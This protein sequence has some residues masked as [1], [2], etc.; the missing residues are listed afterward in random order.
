MA[1]Q[2]DVSIEVG[3]ITD[4]E[5]D[6]IKRM[7]GRREQAPTVAESSFGGP[8]WK[9]VLNELGDPFD[10]SRI[11]MKKRY[12]MRLDPMIAF[13][14]HY[15]EVPLATVPWHINARDKNGARA[16]VA[17]FFD[18]AWRPIHAS[19]VFQH[20]MRKWL[21]YVPIVERFEA[22]N[23]GG[24]Y[25]DPRESD[26]EKQEK[27][28]WDEGPNILPY[29]W[30]HFVALPPERCDPRWDD[31]NGAF[32][33]ITY[34]PPGTLERHP[35]FKSRKNIIKK[36]AVREIDIF[37]SLWITN[38]RHVNFNSIYGYPAVGRAYPY[39][40]SYWFRWAMSDRAFERHAVPP[41]LAYHPEGGTWD[42]D[43]GRNIPNWQIALEAAD[44]LR[45]NAIAAVPSSLET[46]GID[47]G[48]AM[49]AWRFEFLQPSGENFTWMDESFNYL[50]VMKLRSMWVPEQAFIEGEGGTSSR[51]VAAA[52]AESFNASQELDWNDIAE[53][54]NRWIFPNLAQTNYQEFVNN[55]GVVEIVGHGFQQ[56]D[57][58]FAAQIIQLI[59]QEDPGQFGIDG[60]ELLRRLKIPL[61]SPRE[62]ERDRQKVVGA[63]TLPP[64][65]EPGAASVG[66]IPRPKATPLNPGQR[67]GGSL[68]EPRTG[69]AADY[70]MVYIQ[71]NEVI[72]L[73]D[74]ADF[75]A[76]LP[77]SKHY[78]DKQIK[79]LAAQLRRMWAGHY[80][81]LYPNFAKYVGKQ[82]RFD[83]ADE[84]VS[85][86]GVTKK[87]AIKAANALLGNWE[88]DS[89]QMDSLATRSRNIIEK[90]VRR[91]IKLEQD[92][93]GDESDITEDTIEPFVNEQVGRLMKATHETVRD[94][95]KTFL[96]NEIREGKTPTE[97]G[98]NISNH[99]NEF[100][101]WQA[102]RV[103]RAETRDSV[104]AGTLF[105]GEAAKVKYTRMHDGEEHDEECRKRN[106]KL[107]TIKEAWKELRKEH[108]YGTLGFELLPRATFSVEH[109]KTLDDNSPA[110]FDPEKNTAFVTM[111]L[112]DDDLQTFFNEVIDY[113]SNGNGV[114][115]AS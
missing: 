98:Q 61:K 82:E 53:S 47:G 80:R 70:D 78:E 49:P 32:N 28:I 108:P 86:R 25:I 6:K 109:V 65:V 16:D 30:K 1:D 60:Q 58:D 81:M 15:K 84:P 23:P 112:S 31:R 56:A 97:I 72:I 102:N 29:V 90:M 114:A 63:P 52:M 113:V 77:T 99:F 2:R 38:E 75:L 42:E 22:A 8:D 3:G 79:K 12:Q 95:L 37:H 4:K 103:G 54:I 27:P 44:R 85:K 68:P 41:M 13:A 40:W 48:T 88:V 101:G 11:P 76:D 73:S 20:E 71:P 89:E 104:N 105:V 64:P 91:Q 106:G 21:G 93:V 14:L 45:S 55:G 43:E 96:I 24:T 57:L 19:Y 69:V 39:W 35:G 59:G 67:N 5:V 100:P 17:A 9:R 92:A 74:D 87:A 107:A 94:N 33:G 111:N 83:F 50:D 10:F 51:N 18:R 26:P 115:H 66:V 46:A 62:L 36:M 34:R 7:L 110:L